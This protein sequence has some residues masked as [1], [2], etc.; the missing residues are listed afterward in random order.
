MRGATQRVCAVLGCGGDFNPRSPCG[1]RPKLGRNWAEIGLFQSTLPMRGATTVSNIT[2]LAL[3]IS[4]H[5]PHAGSDFQKRPPTADD[6]RFQSTLPMRGA[7]TRY[8]IKAKR[9]WD[10]NPRSP[11]G[12]RP[13]ACLHLLRIKEF[14]S[15]LPMRG[16]TSA[17]TATIGTLN[18]NPRS[19]CGERL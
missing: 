9:P 12:E 7:T 17:I 18:F 3:T 11:C 10:F 1:E 13:R 15:T 5:A 6:K 4:I 8:T 2:F 16:A 14:Q 19:P